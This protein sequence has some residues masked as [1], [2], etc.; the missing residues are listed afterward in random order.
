MLIKTQ[1][2]NTEE[3]RHAFNSLLKEKLQE[4]KKPHSGE[5]KK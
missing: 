2:L 5:K 1:T 3:A 4:G